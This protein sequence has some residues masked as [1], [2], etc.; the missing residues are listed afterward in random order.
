MNLVKDMLKSGE[1]AVGTSASVNSEAAFLADSG[2]DFLLFDT[3][4]SPVEIKDLRSPLSAMR[5][6]KAI[7]IIRVGDL[8]PDQICYALDI[9]AKG[10]IVPMV[11]TK[12]EAVDMV[13]WCKYPFEGVRSSAGMRGEWG[14][15]KSYREYMDAVNEQVLIVPMIETLEAIDNLEDI[16]S[17]PGID[18]LLVGP[19]DLSI[20]LDVALDYPN[21]KYRSAL[22]KIAA[23]CK[24]AGVVPGMYFI[25]PGLETSDLVAMGFRFFTLPWDSWATEGIH[26]G[27]ASVK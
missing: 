26:T 25:P 7:P 19:S 8:R 21:P 16:L 5:G 10:I 17:V 20:N 12:E 23:A 11:N 14:E 24:E 1:T 9:G 4:H 18:V 6:K 13:K 22:E 2:F 3:Q 27:L 15:F